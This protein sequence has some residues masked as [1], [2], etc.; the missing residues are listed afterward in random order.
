MTTFDIKCF[1]LTFIMLCGD[2]C[3]EEGGLGKEI[4]EI[5]YNFC[6]IFQEKGTFLPL[7]TLHNLKLGL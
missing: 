5:S 3:F 7:A 4:M 1:Y 6:C 2:I